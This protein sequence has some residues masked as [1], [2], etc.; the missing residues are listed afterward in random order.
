LYYFVAPAIP[1]TT[2]AQATT[3]LFTS[4]VLAQLLH[5]FDFRSAETT[6]WQPL[7]L[8]NRWLVMSFVGSM[9]L[10]AAIIYVPALSG[11]FK[12]APLSAVH[13]IA[14]IGTGL[15]AVAVID[16]TKLAARTSA[17]RTRQGA[18]A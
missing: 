9:S 13:W 6:V 12:T 8:D 17:R 2:P 7:S 10:Q 15:L 16:A 14:I 11:V 3:I 1:G 4:L 5:A 18:D